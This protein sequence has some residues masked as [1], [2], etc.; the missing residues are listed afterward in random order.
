MKQCLTVQS[1]YRKVQVPLNDIA[2]ITVEGRKTKITR[3]DGRVHLTNR[4]LKDVYAQLPEDTF[5][6]IN[7]GIVV[8]K[9]F[10]KTDDNG[11]IT[12]KDG[13]QFRRRVRSDRLPRRESAAETKP[14]PKQKK[15]ITA[16]V[17]FPA[18]RMTKWLGNMPV[19]LLL[20]ELI[21]AQNKR[22]ELS[23]RLCNQSMAEIL[24]VDASALLGK[25]AQ[26]IP[27]LG[28]AKWLTIFADVALH[29]GSQTAEDVLPDSGRY[30][31]MQCYQPQNGYCGILLSDL[32]RENQLLQ[33][34]FQN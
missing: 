26:T 32:T 9:R 31:R 2:Y 22:V 28:N 10:I 13:T 23:V 15:A 6:N 30:L 27:Q 19:P 5:S 34:L 18:E 33:E 17:S 12:M 21:Y 8:S 20:L 1:D 16:H 7:R 24:G 25:S 11:I 4:S 3:G 29:G 14:R